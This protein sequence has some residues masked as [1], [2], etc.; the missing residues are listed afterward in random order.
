MIS[1]MQDEI[2]FGRMALKIDDLFLPAKM[3]L[4]VL[5]REAASSLGQPL[6]EGG[7]TEEALRLASLNPSR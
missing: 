6:V 5:L 2:L 4:A 3:N 7:R 1:V